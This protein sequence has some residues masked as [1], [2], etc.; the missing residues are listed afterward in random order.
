M[1]RLRAVAVA[2][3]S[4]LVVFMGY[5]FVNGLF[6]FSFSL[7]LS[8][9]LSF[10]LCLFACVCLCLLVCLFACLLVCLLDVESRNDG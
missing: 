7:F 5:T 4:L 2:R 6:S 10:F 9:F 8:F 1:H 3:V